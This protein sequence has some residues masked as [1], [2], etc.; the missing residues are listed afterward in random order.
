MRWYTDLP[1]A[2]AGKAIHSTTENSCL[3]HCNVILYI[4][5]KDIP[6]RPVV[7]VYNI[8]LEILF[9]AKIF[10]SLY[11][12]IA[13]HSQLLYRSIRYTLA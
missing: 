5:N 3:I 7:V 11:T 1:V 10:F 9:R 8:N 6:H 13:E 4:R 12:S 2:V